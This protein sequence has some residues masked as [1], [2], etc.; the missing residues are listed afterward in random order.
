MSVFD[1]IAGEKEL[2]ERCMKPVSQAYSMTAMELSVLLFL[3]NNPE[4]DTATDIV[5]KRHLTKS[6]VSISVRS[7]EERG[8]LKKEYRNGDHRTVHLVL[9]PDCEEAVR[10]GKKAQ[11]EFLDLL[12]KG[13]TKEQFEDFQNY[14]QKMSLNVSE[15]LKIH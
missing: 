10:D 13:F 5:E 4:Y 7:L 1:F 12:L 6:H 8:F 14:I 15:A 3:A 9:L 2:Y 11:A